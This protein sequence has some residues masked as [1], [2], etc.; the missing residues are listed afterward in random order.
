MNA[1]AL[2]PLATRV[3]VGLTCVVVVFQV[4]LAGGAP[5]GH[6]TMGGAFP[7]RL[8]PGMRAAAV[9]QVLLLVTFALVVVARSGLAF[10]R[11]HATSRKLVWLVIA[12]FTIG[13][14]LNAITPSPL[15]RALWLPVVLTMLACVVI[16]TVRAGREEASH[17]ARP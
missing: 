12:Y 14:V 11:W 8:P 15:E 6:L 7:G 2:V 9:V 16:V 5:W 10:P 1:P 4:A 3:F 17:D 13:T